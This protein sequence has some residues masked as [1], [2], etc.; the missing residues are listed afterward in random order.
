[1]A[2][3]NVSPYLT[4]GVYALTTGYRGPTNSWAG[5]R[6]ATTGTGVQQSN[7][8]IRVSAVSGGRGTSYNLSRLWMWA[9][10]QTYAPNITDIELVISTTVSPT[11]TMD[12]AIVEGTGF[13]NSTNS[14]LTTSDFNNLDFATDYYGG[15]APWTNAAGSQNYTLNSTALNDANNNGKL[16][17]C[18]INEQWDYQD[19]DPFGGLS[20][21]FNNY[22]DYANPSKSGFKVTYNAG[23]G[24]LVNGVAATS[25]SSVNGVST[26]NISTINGV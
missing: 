10:L 16:Q 4:G 20:F 21:D 18:V 7:P 22:I 8:A 19:V 13:S 6:N 26:G 3:V 11:I 17:V 5:V 1:M 12:I 9:D 2:V 15:S 14:T 23:Y 24:N 25:I